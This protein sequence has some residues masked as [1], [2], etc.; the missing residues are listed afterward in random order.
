MTYNAGA[1][2]AVPNLY[3]YAGAY[4]LTFNDPDGHQ[5][6]DPGATAAVRGMSGLRRSRPDGHAVRHL[7]GWLRTASFGSLKYFA[8]SAMRRISEVLASV[9]SVGLRGAYPARY[10]ALLPGVHDARHGTG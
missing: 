1:S 2:S 6:Q 5:L 4:P 7:I 10:K 9:C 8:R 3:A